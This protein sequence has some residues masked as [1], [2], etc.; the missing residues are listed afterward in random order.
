MRTKRI[1]CILL[2]IASLLT[3]AYVFLNPSSTYISGFLSKTEQVKANIMIVEGWLPDYAL[4]MAHKE[5]QKNGYKYIITT[6]LILPSDFYNEACDGYLVF[7]L[8]NRFT[9]EKKSGLHSIEIEAYSELEGENCA[10]FNLLINDSLVTDFRADKTIRKYGINWNGNLK[11][12]DSVLIQF[13]NDG[14]GEYGDRNLYVKQIIIDHKIKIPYQNNTEYDVG[15]LDGYRRTKNNFSSCAELAR[16]RLLTMGIDSSSVIAIP[17]KKALINRT[18]KSA[19]AFRD[20]LKTANIDIKGINI[21]SM[22]THT[23]RTWIIY[24][25]ILHRKSEVGII[26]LP[27][28]DYNYSKLKR[29]SKNFRETLAIIYYWFVLIPY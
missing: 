15:A 16:T 29:L 27:D 13:T 21:V 7:Y 19:L 8:R 14:M 26:S 9:E 6:G 2:I 12:I 10:H 22:G 1:I 23:R 25:K 4:E 18:L 17:G 3:L 20:W 11:D 24:S 28:Y 5:F